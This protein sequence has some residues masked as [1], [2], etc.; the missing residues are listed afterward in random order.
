MSLPELTTNRAFEVMKASSLFNDEE[1]VD[2][3]KFNR[4]LKICGLV[5]LL[6]FG[7][8]MAAKLV[9][10]SENLTAQIPVAVAAAD[11]QGA[12]I[13]A[14]RQVLT[15]YLN[16]KSWKERSKF[17]QDPD[18]V[19]PK[20]RQYYEDAANVE[21]LLAINGK[22]HPQEVGG[23]S[24]FTFLLEDLNTGK[25]YAATIHQTN[26]GPRLDWE[27][28][29]GLGAIPWKEFC[30]TR[31]TEATQMRVLVRESEHYSGTFADTAKY[32]AFE[33]RH[34]SGGQMLV[35]Y[36]DRSTR[37][38]QALAATTAGQTKPVPV[39]LYLQ[40]DP[41]TEPDQVTILDMV[42]NAER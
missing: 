10:S 5:M 1:L 18:R 24:W 9:Q 36:V 11:T 23:E 2:P 19:G 40:C 6:T 8:Y 28:F 4:G 34:L 27:S 35:G 16:T 15:N 42:S 33:I 30:T 7:V 29:V 37:G 38:A 20:F 12:A 39:H 32:Q 21:P 22:G 41:D 31:P 25:E 14:A 17:I 26:T 13:S 3:H